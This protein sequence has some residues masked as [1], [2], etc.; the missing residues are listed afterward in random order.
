MC[1]TRDQLGLYSNVFVKFYTDDGWTVA[2]VLPNPDENPILGLLVPS[3]LSLAR[4]EALKQYLQNIYLH[5]TCCRVLAVPHEDH[6]F[7]VHCE[8]E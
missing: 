2:V 3:Y 1:D 8:E 5:R 4:P 7:Y 6:L